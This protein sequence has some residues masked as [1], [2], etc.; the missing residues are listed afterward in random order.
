MLD[1]VE[2]LCH[3]IRH[4]VPRRNSSEDDLLRLDARLWCTGIEHCSVECAGGSPGDWLSPR[5]SGR[6]LGE[7]EVATEGTGANGVTRGEEEFH[8]ISL[9][10]QDS[11]GFL[12]AAD[13]VDRSAGTRR[14]LLEVAVRVVGISE[15]PRE[16]PWAPRARGLR[17][18]GGPQHGSHL[19][20][21]LGRPKLA[22]KCSL[23]RGRRRE[24]DFRVAGRGD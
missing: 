3:H 12:D 16:R 10:G 24:P 8:L 15:G 9:H 13:P 22:D 2:S 20:S 5:R 19:C 14:R 18:E 1:R 21:V 7:I 6:G 4:H 23:L 17:R 11:A